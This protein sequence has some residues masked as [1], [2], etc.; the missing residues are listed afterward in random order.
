M[1]EKVI[2]K[3]Y[4]MPPAIGYDYAEVWYIYNERELPLLDNRGK[5]CRFVHDTAPHSDL[6]RAAEMMK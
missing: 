6:M 2:I 5:P 1:I 3:V 4:R